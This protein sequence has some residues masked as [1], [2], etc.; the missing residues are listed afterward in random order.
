MIYGVYVIRDNGSGDCSLPFFVQNS[1]IARRQFAS[2][3]R[4]LPPSCRGDFAL[5]HIG[6]YDNQ[7][8][9]LSD[10][11]SCELISIGSDDDIKRMIELDTPFYARGN[12]DSAPV[13]MSEA[14]K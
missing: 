12:I 14:S 7:N 13:S 6:T 9:E 10:G 4:T 11:F 5:E 8:Q 3:L 1:V 2:T